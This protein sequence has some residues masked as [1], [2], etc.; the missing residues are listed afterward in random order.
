MRIALAACLL[1]FSCGDDSAPPGNPDAPT[2]GMGGTSGA[3]G[4]GGMSGTDGMAGAG[5]MSD[6][7]PDAAPDCGLPTCQSLDQNSICILPPNGN[8]F[9]GCANDTFCQNTGH[10]VTSGALIGR[11][12][13]GNG[14]PCV[15]GQTIC[16]NNQCMNID[17]GTL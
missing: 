8:P 11:C 4:M 6:G 1:L 15:G 12:R 7:G 5:G 17:G 2:G 3:G 16:V 14:P 13:C 9:C 10:C